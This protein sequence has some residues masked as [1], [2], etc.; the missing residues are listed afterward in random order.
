MSNGNSP[1]ATAGPC[2]LMVLAF[3]LACL[4]PGAVGMAE[5]SVF[6]L[7]IPLGLA[8]AIVQSVAGI[9]ELSRGNIVGGNI[10]LAF[11]AFMWYGAGGNLLKFLN[12]GPANTAAA[13]GWI[14]LVM[15]LCMLGF[16]PIFL[17]INLSMSVFILATDTFFM[18][19]ALSWIL[20]NP[21]LFL[22]GAW[23]LPVVIVAIIW[24]VVGTMLNSAFGKEVIKLGPPLA[25]SVK[26]SN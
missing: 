19:W 5:H 11:S 10:N 16:T 18:G 1:L 21:T 25:G 9:V 14:F 4:W 6:V 20:G 23:A 13:D 3:Y 17:K 8:G 7:L 24:D 15:G 2:G 12:I 22:I 26:A